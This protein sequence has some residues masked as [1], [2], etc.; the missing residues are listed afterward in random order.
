MAT[1]L[2]PLVIEE[3]VT[4]SDV[5]VQHFRVGVAKLIEEGE[6]ERCVNWVVRPPLNALHV[7]A[8]VAFDHH[9]LAEFL[10]L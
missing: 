4:V 9:V 3:H 7:L 10:D 5:V 1:P 8:L 6:E 2:P